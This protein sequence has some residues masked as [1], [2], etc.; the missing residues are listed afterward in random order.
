MWSIF[1]TGGTVCE[2]GTRHAPLE[3]KAAVTRRHAFLPLDLTSL[4]FDATL[5]LSRARV[6]ELRSRVR[7]TCLQMQRLVFSGV[8]HLVWAKPRFIYIHTRAHRATHWCTKKWF[9]FDITY[10]VFPLNF[11]LL[12]L[13]LPL[14][15]CRAF[16]W[17]IVCLLNFTTNF[18]KQCVKS[19]V[20][21]VGSLRGCKGVTSILLK[22]YYFSLW[23]CLHFENFYHFYLKSIKL[24]GRNYTTFSRNFFPKFTPLA[25]INVHWLTDL[26]ISGVCFTI[27]SNRVYFG[28]LDVKKKKHK[29]NLTNT[30]LNKTWF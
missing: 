15:Y 27:L 23:K 22:F 8:S 25:L 13:Q 2:Y 11:P 30:V 16:T 1:K 5:N 26:C 21:K 10:W 12:L 28:V 4:D 7:F 20:L 17:L 29:K 3:V 14:P 24:F 6:G 9:A 18:L 19:V